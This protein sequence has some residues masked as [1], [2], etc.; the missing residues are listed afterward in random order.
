MSDHGSVGVWNR[1]EV[2]VGSREAGKDVQLTRSA[3]AML[4]VQS[5]YLVEEDGQT[6]ELVRVPADCYVGWI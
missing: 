5:G 6:M 3:P 4:C 1:P 2:L